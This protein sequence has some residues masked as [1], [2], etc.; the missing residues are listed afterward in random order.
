MKGNYAFTGREGVHNDTQQVQHRRL[1]IEEN[2]DPE[3][4]G[5][6]TVCSSGFNHHTT[7][8]SRISSIMRE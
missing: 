2:R 4:I 5:G 7:S 3:S 1:M 8:V 6:D